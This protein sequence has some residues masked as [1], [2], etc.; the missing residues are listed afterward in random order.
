MF[1]GLRR[2]TAT[3]FRVLREKE[4][5]PLLDRVLLAIRS[6]V[7]IWGGRS[8]GLREALLFP[9]GFQ[10]DLW[11]RYAGVARA[12]EENLPEPPGRWRVMEIG[13]GG[14]GLAGFLRDSRIWNRID[15]VVV[16]RDMQFI[17]SVR[18]ARAVG[19][20]CT[21]LPFADGSFDCVLAVDILEHLPTAVRQRAAA[22]IR[23]LARR[24]IICHCPSEG[25]DD[26]FRGAWA[27]REYE[28]RFRARFGKQP[29]GWV[30]EH[31]AAGHPSPRELHE[32]FPGS[33]LSGDQNCDV[34]LR[35][36]IAGEPGAAG[37]SRLLTGLRYAASWASQDGKSPFRSTLPVCRVSAPETPQRGRPD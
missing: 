37:F 19:V 12:L 29:P 6:R 3:A 14:E 15:L 36:A 16:D 10:I 13:S 5:L 33:T 28:K 32:L 27:D 21:S 17:G 22:E 25:P 18:R 8:Y 7:Y 24:L 35:Y 11:T 9:D 1:R 26:Q 2:R 4:V 20:D 31:I 30:G 23:P 34:W